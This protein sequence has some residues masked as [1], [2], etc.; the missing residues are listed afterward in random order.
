MAHS[1][2]SVAKSLRA[3]HILYFV[4]YNQK[5]ISYASH[6][7]LNHGFYCRPVIVVSLKYIAFVYF[8]KI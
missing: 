3:Y 1:S 7:K 8:Q 4:Q 2:S 5:L 6:K